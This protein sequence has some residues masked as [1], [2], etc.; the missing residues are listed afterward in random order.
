MDP[1]EHLYLIPIVPACLGWGVLRLDTDSRDPWFPRYPD[2]KNLLSA[3]WQ[4]PDTQEY[5]ESGKSKQN[6]RGK[7]LPSGKEGGNANQV[8]KQ[9]KTVC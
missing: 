4:N 9:K 7:F 6:Y 3:S 1:A 8:N 2:H 5:R